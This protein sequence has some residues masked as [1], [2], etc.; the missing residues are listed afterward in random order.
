MD[1]LSEVLALLETAPHE[2]NNPRFAG[3]KAGGDWA[4]RFG[5]PD[6]LKF[7]AVLA[8]QCW[9]AVDGVAEPVLLRA[10][11]CYLLTQARGYT[12]ASDLALAPVD[13]ADVYRDAPHGIAHHGGDDALLVGGRFLFSDEA[14]FLLDGLPPLALVD[15]SSRQAPVLR[16]ALDLLAQELATSGPGSA[17][18]QRHLG[19][20][21]LVQ[22][23][24]AYLGGG[25]PPGRQDHPGWLAALSDAR[26]HRALVAIH[27]APQQRWSV[28][29]LALVAGMSRS[30]F[31]LHFKQ[32][33]GL[34]PLEYVLRWRMQLACRALKHGTDTV[35]VIGQRL[36]YDSDSAFSNAF[37]R[38]M[39]CS[40]R[41]YR[42]RHQG[43]GA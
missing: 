30:S 27:A 23:M 7:N 3:L 28:A 29:A 24:R 33:A 31:A 39:L 38:L 34:G 12:L 21:M 9:L 41:Q 14:G 25:Q 22:F 1:P 17:L 16:W 35:S 10:G 32:R 18:M 43:A 2:T 36:G 5:Q 4:I 8:G 11:D 37:K 42:A 26:L 19:H 40:P 13:A 6:G 20:M 15:G